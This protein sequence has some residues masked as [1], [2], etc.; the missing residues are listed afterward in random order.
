MDRARPPEPSPSSSPDPTASPP[1]DAPVPAS[2][3]GFLPVLEA[4][5]NAIVAVDGEGSIVYVNR[6]ASETFG[7]QPDE[8]IGA[9]ME[10]LLPESA[11]Q[12]H[13]TH[14][15][16]FYAAPT[17]RPMGI[18][19]DLSG[20]R[21]DGSEF[22]VEI[23]LA[24][25]DMADGSRLA[26]ATVVDITARKSL[27]SRLQQAEK[28]QT[29]GRLAG[30]IAHDFNNMLSAIRGYAD[31][32][33]AGLPREGDRSDTQRIDTDDLRHSATAIVGAADRAA[34]LTAQL[35]AFARQ[36]ILQPR[37]VDLRSAVH[38]LEPLLRR[39]IGE[40]IRLVVR[41]DRTTGRI[42]VD[43]SQLDQIVVNLVVNAKDALPQ[44][45]TITVETMNTR[46]DQP[47]AIEHFEVE[48]GEYVVLAVS[49]DGV[50]MDVETKR[51]IFE[52]FFTTKGVGQGTG[53]GL[54]T[55]YGTVRQSGGHIWLYSEPGRGTTFK[56]FF[57]RVDATTET[58]DAGGPRSSE[59]VP[60]RILVVEDEAFV[61]DLIVAIL[62]RAGHEV[63]AVEDGLAAVRRIERGER[64]DVIVSDVVMP[65][66]SGTEVA[67]TVLERDP[68]ARVILLSGYTAETLDLAA[69]LE[70]GVVFLDKP[71][72]SERLLAAVRAALESRAAAHVD[73]A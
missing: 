17:A 57:P 2:I 7:Y 35:L 11:R 73:P 63:E 4:S 18:G 66:G 59:P 45:G 20:R 3:T 13:T 53:L 69:L 33:L 23:S 21:R 41:T 14:R 46:I 44:G 60:A 19:L 16:S 67:R 27:E 22:P 5:P 47:Y 52:P 32:V 68:E 34:S 9:E 50:G 24:P 30:G 71:F 58:R 10:M 31:L 64:F 38:D 1:P 61:R 42:E 29:I 62:R 56:L 15:T 36:Q 72:A 54:A 6:Q 28:L 12:R 8:L 43:A 65:A 51:H 49:D 25:V 70:R 48:P 55:T 39:L 37:V 40:R 26:F